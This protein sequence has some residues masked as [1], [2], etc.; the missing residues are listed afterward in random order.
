MQDLAF[1]GGE[2]LRRRVAGV[3]GE[4]LADD[5]GVQG[6]AAGGDAVDGGEELVQVG[7]AVLEQLADAAAAVGEEVGGVGAFD[8]LR[9]DEDLR[10]RVGGAQSQGGAEAFVAEA[11]R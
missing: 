8:V 7:D 6:G 1:A 9:H 5:L 11:G 10:G 2:A 3:A 4:Q